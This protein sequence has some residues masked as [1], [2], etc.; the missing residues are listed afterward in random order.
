MKK[1]IFLASI[2]TCLVVLRTGLMYALG[3]RA[4]YDAAYQNV[5]GGADCWIDGYDA[6]FSGQYDNKRA[7]DCY[8]LGDRYNRSLGIRM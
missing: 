2:L 8:D 1:A 4:D 3:P 5:P 6:G 7:A